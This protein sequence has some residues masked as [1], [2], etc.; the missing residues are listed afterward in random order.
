MRRQRGGVS[1]HVDLVKMPKSPVS[2]MVSIVGSATQG[3]ETTAGP[4][5]I[6]LENSD[7]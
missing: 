6:A 4:N 1:G 5:S 7:D 2:V 3:G